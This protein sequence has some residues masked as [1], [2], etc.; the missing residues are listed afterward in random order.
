MESPSDIGVEY[1]FFTPE[2]RPPHLSGHF[3]RSQARVARLEGGSSLKSVPLTLPLLVLAP[4]G[5]KVFCIA[6]LSYVHSHSFR[7]RICP[8]PNQLAENGSTSLPDLVN[9]VNTVRIPHASD[10][11]GGQQDPLP[12]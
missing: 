2:M 5:A 7:L 9:I 12:G 10:V 8:H 11:M 6:I 3:S 4:L 1:K